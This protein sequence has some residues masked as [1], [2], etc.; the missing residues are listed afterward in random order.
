MGN[1]PLLNS[2][3]SGTSKRMTMKELLLV[4]KKQKEISLLTLNYTLDNSVYHTHTSHK[5]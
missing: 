4:E 5:Y 1:I 2:N 3:I